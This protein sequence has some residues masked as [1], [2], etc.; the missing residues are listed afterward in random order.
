MIFTLPHSVAQSAE[1]YPEKEAFRFMNESISYEQLWL[2]MNQVAYLLKDLGVQRGNRVG[3]YVYRSLETAIAMYGIMQA[4]AVYVPLN[5]YAPIVRTQFVMK[6]CGINYIITNKAQARKI[7]DVVIK[8]NQALVQTVIGYKPNEKKHPAIQYFS[9]EEVQQISINSTFSRK[10]LERDLAYI[11]YTSGSTGVPKGIMH[12][13]YSGLSYAKLVAD[14]YGINSTDRIGNHAPIHFDISTLAYFA[15]PLTGATTIIASEPHI[16]MPASLSQL[17]EKEAI[18]TWYSV[19]YA[20]IQMMEKGALEERNWEALRWILYAGEP[21]PTKHLRT[22]MHLLPKAKFSNIYGPT[23]TNQCTNYDIPAPPIT[24][25]PISIGTTWGNTEAL[26]VDKNNEEVK[27]G[28]IGELLIRSATM[29]KGYWGR[30]ALTEKS[31]FI[32]KPI[33]GFEEVFYRTGDLVKRENDGNL[34]FLGRKDR[35]IKTRGYRVELDEITSILLKETGIAEVAVYPIQNEEGIILIAAAVTL[36]E[37]NETSEDKLKKYLGDYLPWYAV[38]A[39]IIITDNLPRTSTGKI[40]FKCL[41]E[42]AK[43]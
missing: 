17:I 36:I 12:T 42:A 24:D 43:V 13:H 10:L 19:P 30:E 15:G 32:R 41:S 20:L 21:F 9:W 22:L 8:E 1:L 18:S 39:Q 33:A 16:K 34:T 2:R 40:D 6:D 37:G 25:D 27:D 3:I 31:L 23:E 26:I 11:L 29:M 7:H 5:P 14:T 28:E 35:Q 38:P 4:G